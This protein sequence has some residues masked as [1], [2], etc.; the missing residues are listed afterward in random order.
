MSM[1]MTNDKTVSVLRDLIE[2]ARD[3]QEGFRTAA[4]DAKD[5]E[6]ARVFTEFSMQRTNFIAELQDRIRSLGGEVKTS[7]SITGSVHRGWMDLKAALS[8]HE[9]HAVLAECERGEDAA[10]SAYR[11]ALEENLDP[12]TRGLVSRQYAS[13]QAA[14]DRVKQLRDSVAMSKR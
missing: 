4:E 10:V 1:N 12:V 13:V 5:S 8:S 9:P 14:H 6:L 7:G 3:G 11:D 2:T